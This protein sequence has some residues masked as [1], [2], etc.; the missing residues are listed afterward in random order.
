LGIALKALAPPPKPPGFDEEAQQI[1]DAIVGAVL[2]ERLGG[3]QPGG[4][5]S[6]WMGFVYNA[7]GDWQGVVGEAANNVIDQW[8]RRR[9]NSFVMK[10]KTGTGPWKEWHQGVPRHQWVAIGA[11]GSGKTAVVDPWPTGGSGSLLDNS[12]S[13]AGWTT[14]K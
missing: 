9:Q 12:A 2:K 5:L 10:L 1:A 11:C 6:T 8:A 4:W 7:C 3:D 13:G 14:V